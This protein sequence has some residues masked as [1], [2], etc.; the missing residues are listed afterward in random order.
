MEP[1]YTRVREGK[2]RSNFYRDSDRSG[3]FRK[4][5]R[6]KKKREK[7][8]IERPRGRA[9]STRIKRSAGRARTLSEEMRRIISLLDLDSFLRAPES[10][11]YLSLPYLD[12]PCAA[13]AA[14]GEKYTGAQPDILNLG[15]YS[16]I[17]TIRPPRSGAPRF[18][19][20]RRLA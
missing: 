17:G 16:F 8:I 5:E 9:R 14:G 4:Q 6:E 2:D 12:S 18:L 20:V 19:D 13:A 3:C 1:K 11:V 10:S 7:E 15:V